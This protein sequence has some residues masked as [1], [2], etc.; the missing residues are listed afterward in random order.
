VF[1]NVFQ[2]NEALMV[3]KYESV[4]GKTFRLSNILGFL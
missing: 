3:K 1:K 2:G 4:L